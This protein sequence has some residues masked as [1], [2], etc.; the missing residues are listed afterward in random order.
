VAERVALVLGGGGMKG[1]AHVGA[2]RAAGEAGLEVTR[3]YGTSI[4]ALVGAMIAA[5]TDSDRLYSLARALQKTDIVLLNRWAVLFNGIRQQSVF[6][7]DSFR[8]F[9]DSV[10]PVQTFE[11]LALPLSVNVVDLATGETEWFGADGRT[12]VPLGDAIYASCALPVFYPPAEIG[13]RYYVDGGVLDSLPV[14]RALEHGNERILAIDVGAGPV[15]DSSDTVSKGMVAI[16]QRV[17]QIVGHAR[18]QEQLADLETEQRITYVRPDL[19]GYN[20]FDFNST[21]YFLAEGY[22]ATRLALGLGEAEDDAD[23]RRRAAP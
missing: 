5:N 15:A 3:V 17:M 22:R 9:I 11:E 6:R 14:A 19:G 12:D 1:L 18:R 4:G 2:W 16:H 23:E 7:G 21:E 20:T 10:L 13:G 8:A